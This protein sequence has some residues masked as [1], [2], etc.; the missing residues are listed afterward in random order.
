VLQR[1]NAACCI[2]PRAKRPIDF[3]RQV[4]CKEH[5]EFIIIDKRT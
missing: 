5:T 2:R 3:D 4:I 1:Y